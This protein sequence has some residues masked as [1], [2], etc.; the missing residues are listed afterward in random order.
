MVVGLGMGSSDSPHRPALANAFLGVPARSQ[1]PNLAFR[2][3]ICRSSID[4]KKSSFCLGKGGDKRR[5]KLECWVYA[6][7]RRRWE[8]GIRAGGWW[9][10]WRRRSVSWIQPWQQE[11]E[12]KI[13]R[14]IDLYT[15]Y[16]SKEIIGMD[17]WIGWFLWR[18]PA[19]C[20]L[21]AGETA[22]I[23]ETGGR[24]LWLWRWLPVNRLAWEM[25]T[26]YQLEDGR[27]LRSC[28]IGSSHFLILVWIYLYLTIIKNLMWIYITTVKNNNLY[29]NK[30][31][32]P[33]S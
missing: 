18:P 21:E 26:I 16:Q 3:R 12:R 14:A 10:E 4:R 1:H 20:L 25:G 27:T 2:T 8:D 17:D 29:N 7:R 30:N 5:K 28:Q 32:H 19:H 15:W 31:H 22:A 11:A 6:H 13:D 24:W 33:K 9:E 23:E